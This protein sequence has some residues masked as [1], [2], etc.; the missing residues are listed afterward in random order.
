MPDTQISTADSRE[1][2]SE[3]L[4]GQISD[5]PA[6]E[7][8]APGEDQGQDPPAATEPDGGGS[9]Q[10]TPQGVA[11]DAGAGGEGFPP[12]F[13][14]LGPGMPS[15]PDGGLFGFGPG[16]SPFSG[17]GLPGTTGSQAGFGDAFGTG[18][19]GGL[20]LG[21]PGAPRF[22]PA[23]DIGLREPA[24][25]LFERPDDDPVENAP[26]APGYSP[27]DP[28]FSEQWYLN[29]TSGG[30]DINVLKAWDDFTGEGVRVA[31]CDDGVDYNHPDLQPNYLSGQGY[32]ESKGIADGYPDDGDNHGTAVAGYIAAAKNGYGIQGVAYEAR[33]AS[34]VEGEAEGALTNVLL[35]Q[36]G[37]DIS[38][39]SW[40]LNP[41]QNEASLM[42][43]L[44]TL[45]RDGRNGLGTVVV[46]AGSNE[47][48]LDILST[49]YNTNNSPY[50]IAVGAVNSTGKYADFSC[51]GPNLLV[52]APGED[53]ISTDRT[54]PAGENAN[55]YFNTGSGTSFSSPIV[56]GVI[57]LMLE[58]NPDLGYRDVQT[59]LASTALRTGSMVSAEN[60]PWDWQVNDASNWNGGGMHASHDYGFGLV[61]AT[62]AVRLAESWDNGQ[63]THANQAQQTGSGTTLGAIPDNTGQSLNSIVNIGTDIVVQHA[64]VTLNISHN[65][66]DDLE[67]RLTSP[68]GTYSDLLYHPNLAGLAQAMK[69]TSEQYMAERDPTFG[70][71]DTWTLSSVM[72][73]GENGNGDWVLTITDTVSGDAGTLNSWTLTLYGDNEAAND[74]YIYTDEY[75]DMAGSDASRTTLDDGSGTDTI[76]ASAVTSASTVDLTPG[77]VST[78]DGTAVTITATTT[79]ENA[80]TGD[81]NDII[82][83]ND[84]D[85]QLFG[86]RGSDVIYGGNGND[87][88]YGGA[89]G[90]TLTGGAGSDIF[91]YASIDDAGDRILDFSHADDSFQFSFSEFGQSATGTLAADRFFTSASQMDVAD[92]CFYLDG[93]SLWYDA[94]GTDT[95][96]SGLEIALLTG[97]AVQSDDITFV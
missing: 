16:A 12:P 1:A 75:S 44:E 81:G 60:K 50:A 89:G 39:N 64:E 13:F 5:A 61:D 19:G 24:F 22:G 46:F 58:A 90:D 66:F 70:E 34:F 83:G 87:L 29:N 68:D 31:V 23:L 84:A 38:Q 35:R 32:N 79:I 91:R 92:A 3:P 37:F 25:P 88:L 7:Q 21:V 63:H 57:A 56:S 77:A 9:A 96:S 51:A 72:P 10:P 45:A 59:I 26:E 76:N 80:H 69:I 2:R 86:W 30:V 85:N 15:M 27:Y 93:N 95:A 47:R 20:A 55:S 97:D 42:G 11:P 48:E 65:R 94:D 62:A 17:S 14:G 6:G 33:I 41:F 36:T 28:L 67:I 54:P 78:I 49:Y 18:L 4:P 82:T 40:T 71:G 8:T 74:Y 53:V 73:M 43:A 52:T